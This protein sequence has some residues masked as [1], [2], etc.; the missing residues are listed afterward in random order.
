MCELNSMHVSVSCA[1]ANLTFAV[2]LQGIEQYDRNVVDM[3][4]DFVYSYSKGVLKDAQAYAEAAG[5]PATS[6]SVQDVELAIRGNTFAQPFSLEVRACTI[7]T[8]IKCK[9]K[10]VVA[11]GRLNLT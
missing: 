2:G 10:I 9:A 7:A 5:T 1:L 4:I 6:I 3:L 11:C 8:V